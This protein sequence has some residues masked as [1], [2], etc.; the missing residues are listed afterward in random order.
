MTLP[1]NIAQF[2][3]RHVFYV[4]TAAAVALAISAPYVRTLS[5]TQRGN[6]MYFGASYL[7]AIAGLSALHLLSRAHA[8]GRLGAI[9]G[10]AR[11]LNLTPRA[12]SIILLT[13]APVHALFWIWLSL[14]LRSESLLTGLSGFNS[15]MFTVLP[16]VFFWQ[17]KVSIGENGIV[18]GHRF[19][20]WNHVRI[21][22]FQDDH[23]TLRLSS[24][25]RIRVQLLAERARSYVLSAATIAKRLPPRTTDT[26]APPD[27][28]SA[29]G[30]G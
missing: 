13:I 6:L 7:A 28:P 21:S 23:M 10:Y 30:S 16:F 11:N 2:R 20:E 22:S 3:L 1:P 25:S 15:A 27:S 24:W 8:Y 4:V 9:V 12:M 17:W 26:P 18:L 5:P 14:Q 29:S 19:Y